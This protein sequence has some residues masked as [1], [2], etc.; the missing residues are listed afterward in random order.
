MSHDVPQN[1]YA[2][3]YPT[4]FLSFALTDRRMKYNVWL[5]LAPHHSQARS[6]KPGGK[7]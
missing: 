2:E 1:S 4:I 7:S 3:I 5:E 6:P